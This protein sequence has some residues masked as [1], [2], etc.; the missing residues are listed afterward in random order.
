MNTG[1]VNGS[2]KDSIGRLIVKIFRMGGQDVQQ[3][4]EATPFGIDTAPPEGM[5]AIYART[6]I[7]GEE[8]IVGYVQRDRIAAPGETRIFSVTDGGDISQFI[9]LRTDGTM[10]IGGTADY[11]VR[12]SELQKGFDQL[13]Q[14]FNDLVN[15]YNLHTHVLALSAGTGTAAPTV[16]QGTPSTA[17]IDDSKIDEIKTI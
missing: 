16:T 7:K 8:V 11:M 3:V 10:E 4:P 6:G 14:D 12:F 1:K 9:H 5:V 2:F 17:S 15:N 13:K